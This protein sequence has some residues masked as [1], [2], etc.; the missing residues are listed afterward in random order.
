MSKSFRLKYII[1]I[2]IGNYI[3]FHVR[4]DK[5]PNETAAAA[6]YNAIA[7]LLSLARNGK[8]NFS[9]PVRGACTC[10]TRTDSIVCVRHRLGGRSANV[11]CNNECV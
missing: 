5:Q 9:V 1:I 4:C 3:K 10:S 11:V 2:C 6:V 7:T 8:L